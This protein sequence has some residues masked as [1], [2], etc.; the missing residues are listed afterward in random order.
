MALLFSFV[1][2]QLV[3][4]WF[5]CCVVGAMQ[6]VEMAEKVQTEP[7]PAKPSKCKH[8]CEEDTA[9]SPAAPERPVQE[10]PTH[11][12]PC[13]KIVQAEVY[14][15]VPDRI[16]DR[17][18]FDLPSFAVELPTISPWVVIANSVAVPNLRSVPLLTTEDILFSHHVLRC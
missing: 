7:I 9:P 18:K 13:A 12:C 15:V 14:T 4:P 17:E 10:K 8:C 1:V 3:A 6:N 2:S 16:I 5:C 11:H